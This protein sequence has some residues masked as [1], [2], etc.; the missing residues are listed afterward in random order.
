M[1]LLWTVLVSGAVIALG[2]Y[3]VLRWLGAAGLPIPLYARAPE[4]VCRLVSREEALKVFLLA[5]LFRLV[6]FAAVG[7]FTCLVLYPG[8]GPG[9]A[10][11]TWER[12]DALH[13]VNLAELGYSGYIEDGKHLFLVFFPLYPWLMRLVS[14]LTGN[15]MAAGLLISFLSYAGG[16]V[17]LYKLAAWELGVGAA[18]R[19]VLFLSIFPY[20]FFFGGIMTESLFFLTTAAGLWYIR[21]HHWWLA[22]VIGI[23]AA[24]TRMH[25]ILLIGAATAEL[26]EDRGYFDWKEI[27]RRLP[28]LLLPVLGT[29]IYLLLNW[30]VGG[31]PFTFTVMQEHW[32]QGFCWISDTLWY[33]LQNALSYPTEAVRYQLWIPT[34]LLFPVFFALAVYA[35][36]RMRSMYVLYGYVYLVLNYS[37]S[38][39]LSAGRYLSCAL[40]F[41]LFMAALTEKRRWLTILAAVGMSIGFVITLYGYLTGGQIM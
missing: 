31:D 38:W 39:L 2:I 25:G 32:S 30:Q 11:W 41:F 16:C 26:V 9:A 33:V 6:I 22:G 21:R 13:Y 8:S 5:L 23:L 10:L 34:I 14:L 36:K 27:F 17:Y 15:T 20:A 18:R 37:L 29:L 3:L 1:E 28:A 35:R 19:A 12:W 40:P 7:L 4:S 24:M